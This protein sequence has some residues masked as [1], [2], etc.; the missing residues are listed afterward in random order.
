MAPCLGIINTVA[1]SRNP[2]GISLAQFGQVARGKYRPP[3]IDIPLVRRA[4]LER[5]LSARKLNRLTLVC[6]PSG[7][8]KTVF[9]AQW[10]ADRGHAGWAPKWLTIDSDDD[11]SERF[12]PQLAMLM[13][14]GAAQDECSLSPGMSGSLDEGKQWGLTE[15]SSLIDLQA[16]RPDSMV[17]IIDCF[18]AISSPELIS[19]I[20]YFIAN[21]P[22]NLRL[23]LSSKVRPPLRCASLRAQGILLELT[24]KDLAFDYAE[25]TILFRNAIGINLELDEIAYLTRKSEG[26][27]TGLR[28]FGLALAAAKDPSRLFSSL[29]GNQR[30]ISDYLNETCLSGLSDEA[31]DFMMKTSVLHL[32]APSLCDSILD[33][34]GSWQLLDRLERSG[35]MTFCAGGQRTWYRYHPLMKDLL[36]AKLMNTVPN[37]AADLNRRAGLW[38]HESGK[39]EEAIPYLIRGGDFELASDD[40]V[41]IA[42]KEFK[43]GHPVKVAEWLADIPE[44]VKSRR[45]ELRVLEAEAA[46]LVG[47]LDDFEHALHRILNGQDLGALEHE[48]E[49]LAERLAVLNLVASCIDG[50]V[51]TWPSAQQLD[52]L[53]DS[54]AGSAVVGSAFMYLTLAYFANDM[55]KEAMRT[56]DVGEEYLFIHGIEYLAIS[57]LWIRVFLLRY[58]GRLFDAKTACHGLMDYLLTCRTARRDDG[59]LMAAV[60]LAQIHWEIDDLDAADR[61]VREALNALSRVEL[62]SKDQSVGMGAYIGLV[63]Y[64][65]KEGNL[66]EA[67]RLN[68]RQMEDYRFYR[69]FVCGIYPEALDLQVCIW[70]AQGSRWLAERWASRQSDDKRIVARLAC[71]RVLAAWADRDAVNCAFD[72]LE[73]CCKDAGAQHYLVQALMLD[74]LESAAH[75]DKG[76]AIERLSILIPLAW[77]LG[78]VRSIADKGKPAA[79]MLKAYLKQLEE[80]Q[81]GEDREMANYVRRL[82]MVAERYRGPGQSPQASR[83][84]RGAVITGPLH[85]PLSE[86]EYE[87]LLMLADA[88]PAAEIARSLHISGNTVKVHIRHIYKKLNVHSR[89]EAVLRLFGFDPRE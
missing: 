81:C 47:R 21:M 79:V 77:R 42:A 56:L 17:I 29:D 30:E 6:A 59:W 35:A 2:D 34:S 25:A 33:R 74:V 69:Q 72:E 15:L 43:A 32:M 36:S 13:Q 78:Y 3:V 65:L 54:S 67:V 23:V 53:L 84:S 7:Y 16:R 27:V 48:K 52:K 11:C 57:A 88:A 85:N 83:P 5:L 49:Y 76:R 89:A 86:R 45:V 50:K 22:A 4:R 62:M 41:Q 39:L 19:Q 73:A 24:R 64:F 70:L 10:A 75:G 68:K 66:L 82:I 28:F 1:P 38:F 8:G 18:E 44:D 55:V 60:G 37:V 51:E 20:D 63:S 71:C 31:R 26:W 61:Y 87:V 12:W 14:E 9:L 46:V 58:Q 80:R 40:L